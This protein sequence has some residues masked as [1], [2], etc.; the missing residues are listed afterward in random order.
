MP[1]KHPSMSIGMLFKPLERDTHKGGARGVAQDDSQWGNN[2]GRRPCTVPFRFVMGR[3][4]DDAAQA[5]HGRRFFPIISGYFGSGQPQWVVKASSLVSF[6]AP[7]FFSFCKSMTILTLVGEAYVHGV[8][9]GEAIEM[10]KRGELE[11]VV[12]QP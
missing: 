7:P 1:T 9:N 10:W 4:Y 2:E 6:L 3:I 5:C 8:M 12:F 11:Q